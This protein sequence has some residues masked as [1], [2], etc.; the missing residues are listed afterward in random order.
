MRV[1]HGMHLTRVCKLGAAFFTTQPRT[2]RCQSVHSRAHRPARR[3][4]PAPQKKTTTMCKIRR[5]SASMLRRASASLLLARRLANPADTPHGERPTRP[6]RAMGKRIQAR[7]GERRASASKERASAS[8]HLAGLCESLGDSPPSS[9]PR[10]CVVALSS[11]SSSA[12]FFL[13]CFLPFPFL[14]PFGC[15]PPLGGGFVGGGFSGGLLPPFG[16]VF[17]G[18][19]AAM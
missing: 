9:P 5:A 14:P 7:E 8:T 11:V 19:R 13:E 16:S 1:C 15:L 4:G 2:R 17:F 12:A 18:A 10:L 3:S 6:R